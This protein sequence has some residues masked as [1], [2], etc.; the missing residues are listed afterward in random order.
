MTGKKFSNI[1]LMKSRNL[2]LFLIVFSILC[3][4]G[5][6][7][8]PDTFA[9]PP[10]QIGTVSTSA[11]NTQVT[12][13]WSAPADNG[14]TITDYIIQYSEGITYSSQ[15]GS[16]GSD[17]GQFDRPY[18]AAIDSSGNIYVTDSYNHRIQKFDSSGN[19]ISKFGSQGS[20]NG[21][22]QTP[23]SITIDYSD[24]IYVADHSNHRIQKFDSSGNFISKFGSSG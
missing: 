11:G 13:S 20:G 15:F 10:S 12:L 9:A 6:F 22:F 1:C 3:S 19:F 2:I 14:A 5:F 17:N 7:L 24:N 8:P 18:S 4:P 16:E 21:Q 23:I